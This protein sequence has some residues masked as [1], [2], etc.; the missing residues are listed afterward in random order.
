MISLPRNLG[1]LIAYLVGDATYV[2]P[3]A[4]SFADSQKLNKTQLLEQRKRI[5]KVFKKI[6]YL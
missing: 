5:F 3:K 1:I 2:Q 4:Y 6:F